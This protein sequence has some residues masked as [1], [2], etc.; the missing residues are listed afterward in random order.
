MVPTTPALLAAIGV[1]RSAAGADYRGLAIA[2]NGVSTLLYAAN[3]GQGTVDVFDQHF[4]PAT[5]SSGAFTDPNLPAGF[6]P[7]NVQTLGNHVFVTYAQKNG[8]GGGVID[9]FNLDGT[10]VARVAANGPKAPRCALGPRDRA[11]LLRQP[12]RHAPRRQSRE[13]DH[14]CLRPGRDQ[15]A[16]RG[17]R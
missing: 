10:F 15:C 13:R 14:R 17:A 6:A 1:N 9:S 11:Q 12:R 5:P 2:N 3:F 7:F 16:A 4:A 8:T